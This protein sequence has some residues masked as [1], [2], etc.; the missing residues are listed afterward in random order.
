MDA[1]SIFAKQFSGPHASRLLNVE[2]VDAEVVDI[3]YRVLL[4]TSEVGDVGPALQS[5]PVDILN[6]MG[7]ALCALRGRSADG[8]LMPT[9]IT[10]RVHDVRPFTAIRS[11]KA[12]S[13]GKLVCVRG[14]VVRVGAVRPMVHRM[15]FKCPRCESEVVV[16][17]RDGTYEPPS[18]RCGTDGCKGGRLQPMRD[19]A[20]ARDWQK[21][22]LQEAD[23][24]NADPGRVPRTVEV[25]LNDDLVDACVPGDVVNVTG[26]VK[27]VNVEVAQGKGTA[28]AR[29]LYLLYIEAVS[30]TS[31]KSNSKEIGNVTFTKSDIHLFQEQIADHPHTFALIVASICPPIFG[32]H[33]VKAGLALTLFGGT[34]PPANIERATTTRPDPHML[35]VGDPGLGKSQ[36]LQATSMLAPRSVYVCG[37]VTTATGL[38]VT[39]VRDNAGAYGLEAG[40]LV[41]GDR[42][43]CCIDEFDKMSN[44][45][46]ALLEAMEQQRISIAKA[47]IV[48]TLSARTSVIAA[49]NP[50]GG[51]YDRGKTIHENLKMHHALLSRFD[52]IF[53]LMD[54]PDEEKDRRLS[55][56]IIGM[57]RT[58]ADRS[59]LGPRR[60]RHQQAARRDPSQ[61]FSTPGLS[62]IA[63]SS[64]R[65]EGFS[66]QF[67][68]AGGAVRQ[69][70]ESAVPLSERLVRETKY[71]KPDGRGLPMDEDP[72]PPHV[73]KKYIQFARQ[74]VHPR[75]TPEAAWVLQQFYLSLREKQDDDETTP[76]TTRQL[77]AMIRLS[78]ARAKISLRDSVT[79]EDAQDVVDIMKESLYDVCT[80]ELGMVDFARTT[81]MSRSKQ[82]K[83]L[84]QALKKRSRAKGSASF[85]KDE[86]V[87]LASRLGIV[88]DPGEMIDALSDQSYML[89]K[90][91]GMFELIT[92][93]G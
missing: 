11:L 55:R 28:K 8:A 68:V 93:T 26:I 79:R 43:V 14:N 7:L 58:G 34:Q 89:R 39:M 2:L 54:R 22:K 17:F 82:L 81:G 46:T 16:D 62:T 12:N 24:D 37:G 47:G 45:H 65:G 9:K 44:E 27:Y 63:A 3:D 29:S 70:W 90:G 71:V 38:T 91:R 88:D 35:I 66:E 19:T 20:R 25:E 53:I 31:V 59:A 87:E 74:T 67:G 10:V 13:L 92:F 75:M 56:H 50:V 77:E 80:D 4:E 51:H 69:P 85:S 64:Q 32:H 23:D 41:L 40:A 61:T 60:D 36:M 49:A 1:I 52:L 83:Q 18:N 30:V 48:C 21:L 72:I 84:V 42:G 76:I 6:L 5:E 33:M 86:I 15:G 73:L 78:Q 57:R